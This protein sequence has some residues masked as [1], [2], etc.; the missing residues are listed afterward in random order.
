MPT[1]TVTLAPHGARA[2]RDPR[3][4]VGDAGSA[5]DSCGALV[6]R[7]MGWGSGGAGRQQSISRSSS[8]RSFTRPPSARHGTAAATSREQPKTLSR[9]LDTAT[10]LIFTGISVVAAH[11]SGLLSGL[12]ALLQ[13]ARPCRQKIADGAGRPL[14]RWWSHKYYIDELYAAL[15][16][17]PL[18]AGSTND[19]LERHRSG[20]DR[21]R[22][23]RQ[24][25]TERRKFPT[26]SATCSP[27]TFAPTP[28]GSR[29]GAAAVIAY[30]VWM[31]T[32]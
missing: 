22:G 19:S 18:I 24:R 16:I 8:R 30:M 14:S 23:G 31:G 29:L 20:R 26:Q 5:G 10:E 15:F 1:R 6:R 32:R 11:C 27:A 21:R 25:R 2:R 13:A 9:Q 17:K 3:E 4:S 7:R 28:A 12:V